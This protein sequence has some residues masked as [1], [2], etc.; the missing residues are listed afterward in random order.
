MDRARV[1]TTGSI[2]DDTTLGR[3]IRRAMSEAY[4]KHGQNI[5]SCKEERD[6]IIRDK[7]QEFANESDF[8]KDLEKAVKTNSEAR[9]L[10]L[11]AFDIQ[12]PRPNTYAMMEV[13]TCHIT[14]DDSEVLAYMS[15][16]N[17]SEPITMTNSESR[18]SLN[19]GNLGY[20][21]AIMLVVDPVND[22]D[23]DLG[24]T[25]AA[26][27]KEGSNLSPA[28]WNILRTAKAG[29]YRCVY[30]DCDVSPSADFETFN[31]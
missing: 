21:F 15:E 30:I 2:L 26:C 22:D 9:D 20:G 4:S 28:F 16:C 5:D 29:G 7:G 6:R 24:D 12:A 3:V 13:S 31:W 23:L 25:Q 10:I 1:I 8:Y 18:S 14:A 19:V 11:S 17:A 27:E